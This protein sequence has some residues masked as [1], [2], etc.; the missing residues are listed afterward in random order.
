MLA[1]TA[2]PAAR[3]LN[4]CAPGAGLLRRRVA[5]SVAASFTPLAASV[6]QSFAT[7]LRP[8]TVTM[9]VQASLRIRRVVITTVLPITKPLPWASLR[10]LQVYVRT[11]ARPVRPTWLL[12]DVAAEGEAGCVPDAAT[13]APTT[14]AAATRRAETELGRGN[15]RGTAAI[16]AANS[17]VQGMIVP[18][19]MIPLGSNAFFSA[20]SIGNDEPYS[21]LTHLA[22]ALPIP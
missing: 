1:P 16:V 10:P 22:R 21:S 7:M 5:R 20:S 2:W 4:T 12:A 19:F 17:A 11:W 18:L 15:E 8:L 9:A 3:I 13:S 6:A 14:A